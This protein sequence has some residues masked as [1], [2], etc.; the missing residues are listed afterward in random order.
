MPTTIPTTTSSAR[1]GSPST[2]DAYFETDT[3]NYIIYDGTNWR[4]Y[5]SDGIS[6]PPIANTY[7]LDFDGT[8]DYI[9]AT[10]SSQV[11]NGDFTLSMWFK[12]DTNPSFATVFQLGSA[13]NYS[14]GFRVYRYSATNLAFWKG[15]GGFSNITGFF[16]STSTGTWY[17]LAFTRSGSTLTAYINGSSE[18]TGTDSQA[19]TST[20]LNASFSTYPFDG[21]IDELAIWDSAL[22]GSEISTIYNAGEPIDVSSNAGSYTSS[23]DLEGWWRMGDANSGTGDVA[24]SSSNSNTATNNGATY[25]SGAGDT[26]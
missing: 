4:S 2:G 26:P 12:A 23:A 14:D 18:A 8:N 22:T 3:N 24:D 17:N 15:Q 13:S 21:K 19:Y 5:N 16:G 6:I 25:V 20:A 10:L 1:P 11:F 9:N 7:S